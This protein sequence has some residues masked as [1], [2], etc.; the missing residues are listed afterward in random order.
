MSFS[1]FREW[2]SS[3]L[4]YFCLNWNRFFSKS[5]E[6]KK[7]PWPTFKK[8]KVL[9][10][11]RSGTWLLTNWPIDNPRFPNSKHYIGSLLSCNDQPKN[12]L[13]IFGK[14]RALDQRNSNGCIPK[15]CDRIMANLL[16]H[17]IERAWP[18]ELSKVVIN[19]QGKT[20]D[21]VSKWMRKRSFL[22]TVK[23]NI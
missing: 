21:K 1:T 17:N 13:I 2:D 9:L 22:Q 12:A 6:R 5:F 3:P 16:S 19:R 8:K 20:T 23:H 4:M 7:E 10:Q 11:T 18:K 14:K 15:A